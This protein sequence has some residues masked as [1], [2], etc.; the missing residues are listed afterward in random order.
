M[1][2]IL[3][4]IGGVGLLP[5]L[6]DVNASESMKNSE[7]SVMYCLMMSRAIMRHCDGL[8]LDVLET[9]YTCGEYPT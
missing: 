5:R 7:S 1:F 4:S 3:G 2:E 6:G 8:R 9:F